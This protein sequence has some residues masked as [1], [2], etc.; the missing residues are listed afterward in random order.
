MTPNSGSVGRSQTAG[1]DSA[2]VSGPAGQSASLGGLGSCWSAGL[3]A[4]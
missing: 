3:A 2:R 1:Y 4:R